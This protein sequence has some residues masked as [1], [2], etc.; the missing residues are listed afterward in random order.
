VAVNAQGAVLVEFDEPNDIYER[1][2]E[3]AKE[4]LVGALRSLFSGVERVVL[5]RPDRPSAAASRERLTSEGVKA[6]R[7]AALRKKDPLLGAAIDAL[8]LDLA[9]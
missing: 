4:E 3:S 7:L 5:R 1:A 9:D 8:D 2:F 6:Q